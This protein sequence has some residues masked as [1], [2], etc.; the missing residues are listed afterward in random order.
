MADIQGGSRRQPNLSARQLQ[1]TER[2]RVCCG[3]S[4]QSSS[5]RGNMNIVHDTH[6]IAVAE[7]VS[8][9]CQTAV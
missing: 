8:A 9:E 3:C 7:H 1:Q 4:E 6:N 2:E 5:S